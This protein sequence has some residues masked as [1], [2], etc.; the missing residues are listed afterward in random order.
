MQKRVTIKDIAKASGFSVN[1]VS[2]ALMDASDISEKTKTAIRKLADEMGYVYNI[3][4]AS[5]RR[6]NSR[7]IGILYDSLLNPFYSVMTHYIEQ[8]LREYS[9]SFVTFKCDSAVFGAEDVKSIISRNVDGLL[10]FLEPSQEASDLLDRSGLPVVVVGRKAKTGQRYVILDDVEGGRI[11]AKH[12]LSCGYRKPVYLGDDRVLACTV[13]RGEGFRAACAENG[14][15]AG[16]YYADSKCLSK[17]AELFNELTAKGIEFDSVFCFNDYAA[18]EVLAEMEHRNLTGIG[19]V[20]FD[21]IQREIRMPGR[22]TTIG[23]DKSEFADIAVKIIV[24]SIFGSESFPTE[25][26]IRSMSLVRGATTA[27]E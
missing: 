11:A 23:Y 21:N 17:Y 26:V 9:Y 22:L 12:L 25:N 19:V 13:E 6:G 14:V 8:R 2:R 18:Y 5:L 7:T 24:G 1:C 16:L 4:A 20:G 15:E 10:S 27:S 3:T